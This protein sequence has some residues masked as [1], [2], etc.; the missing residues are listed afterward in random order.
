[1]SPNW[2][3]STETLLGEQLVE[4]VAR[5]EKAPAA[6]E[7]GV[8]EQDLRHLHTMARER[9]LPDTDEVTLAHRGR[10]LLPGQA[11]LAHRDAE[12][13]HPAGDRPGRHE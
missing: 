2:I 13:L 10:R 7:V 11:G 8:G 5:V 12:P 3:S 6:G 1:L 9:L 4:G